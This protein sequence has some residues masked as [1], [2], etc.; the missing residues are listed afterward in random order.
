MR[1]RTT[2]YASTARSGNGA[3]SDSALPW[4]PGMGEANSG[5]PWGRCVDAFDAVMTHAASSPGASILLASGTPAGFVNMHSACEH[6]L[7]QAGAK[8]VAG[9]WFFP[10]KSRLRIARAID[11]GDIATFSDRRFSLIA[12]VAESEVIC[13]LEPLLTAE[14]RIIPFL[15]R[16]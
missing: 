16:R 1:R 2:K 7:P 10:N 3:R 11:I 13:L 15:G 14:G 4:W 5:T 8:R 9:V 12:V 6:Y